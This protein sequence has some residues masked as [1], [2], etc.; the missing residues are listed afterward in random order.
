MAKPNQIM[1]GYTAMM[2]CQ[3]GTT[4]TPLTDTELSTW[5]AKVAPI[6]GTV[7]A[8][9]GTGGLQVPVEQV[10]DF[11][12]DDA[13]ASFSVAGARTGAKITV[14]DAVSSLSVT[15]AWNPSDAAMAVI[16]TDGYSGAVVRTYV[17]SVSDGTK[18]I[19]YAFNARV[20]GLKWS[21]PTAGESKFMF[22]LHPTGGTSYGWSNP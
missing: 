1:P 7:H 3:S 12:S 6:V 21:T 19:A 11:G 2:W 15:C 4:P 13:H 5:L 10:P 20:G 17:I 8:G 22:T 18:T 14:Q 9:T 16:Q